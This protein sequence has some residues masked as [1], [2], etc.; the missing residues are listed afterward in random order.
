MRI[1]L[2]THSIEGDYELD[3]QREPDTGFAWAAYRWACGHRLEDVLDEVGLPAGDFVRWCKQLIDLLGQIA[4]A[5]AAD[6]G[7]G[8]REAA[9]EAVGLIRR[10]VV[11]Y[12]S[13][14]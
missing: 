12:S 2:D 13:V 7:S 14:T 6:Q 9:R 1:W 3:F 4:D 10:G 8:V 11:A 5:A